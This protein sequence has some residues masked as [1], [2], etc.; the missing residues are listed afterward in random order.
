[1]ESNHR[2]RSKLT[3]QTGNNENDRKE[4]VEQSWFKW[5]SQFKGNNRQKEVR[6]NTIVVESVVWSLTSD[7]DRTKGVKRK[8]SNKEDWTDSIGKE[9]TKVIHEGVWRGN[10]KNEID[11]KGLK[12]KMVIWGVMWYNRVGS[13]SH[14]SA[15]EICSSR[16]NEEDL[17]KEVEIKASNEI[18]R[19]KRTV[20][21]KEPNER[22][23]SN[24][25]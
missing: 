19:T 4:G 9:V 3:E 17:T 1:M 16:L 2:N 14:A 12:R 13:E 24:G 15:T 23:G 20:E 8:I 10:L 11:S 5:R 21:P 22:I 6:W 25:I 18:G 7:W